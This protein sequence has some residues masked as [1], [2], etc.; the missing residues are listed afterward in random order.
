[1]QKVTL[2]LLSALCV[3]LSINSA[4]GGSTTYPSTS[5]I[6]SSTAL[7]NTTMTGNGTQATAIAPG[8]TTKTNGVESTHSLAALIVPLSVAL[9]KF[10]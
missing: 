4:S 6:S 7:S 8:M 5:R 3:V 1:M 10:V 2:F 9:F